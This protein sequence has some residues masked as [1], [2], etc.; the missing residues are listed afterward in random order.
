MPGRSVVAHLCSGA[1]CIWKQ[2]GLWLSQ[3]PGSPPVV[4][5]GQPLLSAAIV[6]QTSHEG[7][8]LLLQK[9]C[10]RF[11]GSGPL[12]GEFGWPSR[13]PL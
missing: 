13:G 4:I 11:A 12:T 10:T 1:K 5:Y 6:S 9:V 2:T 7:F 8:H 3:M